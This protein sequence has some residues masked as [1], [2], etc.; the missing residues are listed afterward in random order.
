MSRTQRA[1]APPGALG[2][3]AEPTDLL[4][5]LSDLQAWLDARRADLDRL[6]SAARQ[7]GTEGVT[8]DVVLALTLRQAVRVRTACHRV[9]A[10]TTSA[11][12]PSVPDWR[13]AESSRSR[14]A[15]RASSQA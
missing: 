6:D 5:Y 15:R 13:A 4:T 9:R 10:S 12:T 7:S 8:A 14:S 2:V 1:P 11:V 3:A